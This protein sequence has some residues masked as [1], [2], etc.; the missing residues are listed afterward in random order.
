MDIDILFFI[1][2]VLVVISGGQTIT[3][4]S[5]PVKNDPC[6]ITCT[7]PDFTQNVTFFR[8][9]AS[10]GGCLN[11][12]GLAF[13]S[14][15]ISQMGNVTKFTISSLSKTAHE[16]DWTCK[17]GTMSST[18]ETLTVYSKDYMFSSVQQKF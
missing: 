12:G 9:S 16:G 18:A 2:C 6:L 14:A 10:Q 1:N 13:C 4:C 17:Y 8:G 3:I 5:N 15:G 11:I 7:T